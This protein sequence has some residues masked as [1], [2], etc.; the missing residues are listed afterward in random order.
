MTA[1]DRWAAKAP[2]VALGALF[3]AAI[4]LQ[5]LAVEESWGAAYW[6]LGT[7][8]SVVVCALALLR[9]RAL[10]R[11]AVAGVGVAAVTVLVGL[12]PDVRLP[13]EPGPAM[14]LGLAVLVGSAVR[15][16]SAPRAAVL[17]AAGLPLIAGQLAARPSSSVAA[18]TAVGWLTAV[19]VG[20][21]ARAHDDRTRATADGVRRAERLELARELHDVVAHH[22][23]G[24]LIEAQA[25]QVVARRDPGKV[26]DSLAEIEAAGSEALVAMR[27][28]VGLL[29]DTDD[30]AP[31]SPGPEEL[32]A[33]V[34]RFARQGPQVRLRTPEGAADWPPE[35]TSTVY[36]IVQEA[37]TNVLRHA[38]GARTVEVDV[39]RSREGVA[40][41]VV[42][43][44]PPHPARPRPRGGYGLVGMRERVETLGGSLH[45]GPRP[46][47]GWSVRATLPVPTREPA[48]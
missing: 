35:V 46:G 41:E 31:A 40:V 4:A 5:A 1:V 38:P 16:L 48:P 23:T 8:A 21:W 25:A 29:R 17:A 10:M 7:V 2:A 33:L 6:L 34:E 14:T 12:L 45:A 3:L 44:A 32:S 15:T 47:P 9:H 43:D 19:A 22:I 11:T 37:L 30:A 28:V 26:P 24:M 42:D 18:I 20:L 27:R 39:A 36:R 13:A